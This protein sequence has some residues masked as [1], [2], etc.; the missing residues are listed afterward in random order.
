MNYKDICLPFKKK[1]SRFSLDVNEQ[2]I[3]VDT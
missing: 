3:E 1:D 2:N